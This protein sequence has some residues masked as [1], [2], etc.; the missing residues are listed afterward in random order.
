MGYVMSNPTQVPLH[1]LTLSI[2]LGHTWPRD[3]QI[4][5]TPWA[6]ISNNPS[7]YY[8]SECFTLPVKLQA[9]ERMSP[10]HVLILAE[11]LA[12]TS[13]ANADEPFMFRH[14]DDIHR[15]TGDRHADE[16]AQHTT[17]EEGDEENV[18]NDMEPSSKGAEKD[19]NGQLVELQQD[20][21]QS[22]KVTSEAENTVPSDSERENAMP[23]ETKQDTSEMRGKESGSKRLRA[24]GRRGTTRSGMVP[25]A[26]AE[27]SR[28]TRSAIAT[29]STRTSTRSTKRK[30][31]DDQAK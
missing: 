24:R 22:E 14:K 26:V 28:T 29:T 3:Q 21:G 11:Y 16:E 17:G 20:E 25:S 9:P 27:S 31:G 15:R 13:S 2:Y 8:D 4:A 30:A 23:N 19:N 10:T 12:A 5:A 6:D 18:M 1:C 7:D